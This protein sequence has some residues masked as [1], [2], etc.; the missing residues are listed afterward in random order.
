MNDNQQTEVTNETIED[1]LETEGIKDEEVSEGQENSVIE[2]NI[3][4]MDEFEDQIDKS[5][6]RVNVGDILTGS[7]V[8]VSDTEVTLDLG[9]YAEG[10]IRADEF[11]TDPNFSIVDSVTVGDEVSAKVINTDDGE[12]NILLSKKQADFILAWDKMQEYL[13][14]ETLVNV[15]IT[16]AVK[17]GVIAPIEG[18]RG[19][20]PASQLSIRY[21]EN[22]E[23]WEGKEVE[24]VVI[25]VDQSKNRL[26]LSSKKVEQSKRKEDRKE[27]LEDLNKGDIVKGTVDNIVPYGA[28]IKLDNGLSGL[29]HISQLSNKFVKTPNEVVKEG[30][31][32]TTKIIDV[33]DGKI[34]L[35]M[36]ALEE[37]TIEDKE[38]KPSNK[39][40]NMPSNR[41]SS[42]P[43]NKPS[44]KAKSVSQDFTSDQEATTNLGDLLKDLDLD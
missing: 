42:K 4:S 33:K 34:N 21:V 39:F 18:I 17:G 26:V 35:S 19:F 32:V 2:E 12:G 5:F 38:S 15:K 40:N 25:T 44:S 14:N 22:L 20:I 6:Q 13:D 30:E 9:S 24:A 7:V 11:S 3:P 37:R 29:I 31:E 43:R 41:P 23:E 1:N 27:L 36:K 10:V 28:F 16:K 8:G